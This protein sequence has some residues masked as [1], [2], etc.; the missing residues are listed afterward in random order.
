MSNSFR[1]SLPPIRSD[2]HNCHLSKVRI[3][4]LSPY[5][6]PVLASPEPTNHKETRVLIG[7]FFHFFPPVQIQAIFSFSFL[8]LS[9][10]LFLL[11]S[12]FFLLSS[13]F[14]FILF[15]HLSSFIFF[16]FSFFISSFLPFSFSS[17]F[18]LLSLLL[19]FF[20][21]SFLFLL[22]FLFERR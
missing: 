17:S 18:F 10:S 21:L 4:V 1:A 22:S 16:I 6:S 2:L 5:L 20:F 7:Q 15:F 11:S 8:L 12:S 3:C 9:S 19:S 13:V 14:F